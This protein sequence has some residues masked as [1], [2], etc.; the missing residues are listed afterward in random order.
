MNGI[1]R[2]MLLGAVGLRPVQVPSV[3]ETFAMERSRMVREQLLPR[4]IT[5]PGVLAAM[6]RVPR[7]AFVPEALRSQA[8]EDHPLPLSQGQTISQPFVVAFM[9]QAVAPHPTDRVLEIGTGSGYQ[10]AVISTLV[11]QVYT[12]ELLEPLA[13]RATEDLQR[14]GF[15]NVQVRCG[16]GYKG[17]PEE[18]PFDVIL[19]TCAPEQVPQPLIDQLTE[20]GRMI[21]PVGSREAQE[22]VLLT[23]RGGQ[24][25]RQSV[26][27]VRFVPM[28]PGP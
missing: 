10:A 16:D 12:L 13:R 22:L 26:L 25:K 24:L 23:K 27:P 21:I 15:R 20:G 5:H 1:W 6:G 11:R 7:H 8:Y 17:W 2:A 4:G 28:V 18:A 19:V 9:T 3:E 14:L